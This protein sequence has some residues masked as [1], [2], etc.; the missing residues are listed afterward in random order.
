ML[1]IAQHI[2]HVNQ[3]ISYLWAVSLLNVVGGLR[4]A[5]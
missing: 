1:S 2:D 4:V 5:G 3:F